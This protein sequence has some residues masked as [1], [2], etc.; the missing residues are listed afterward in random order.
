MHAR[1]QLLDRA[2]LILTLGRAELTA[3]TR[4]E[5]LLNRRASIRAGINGLRWHKVRKS[6]SWLVHLWFAAGIC[7]AIVGI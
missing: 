4:R 7:A 2:R 6:M 3:M 5:S 1:I